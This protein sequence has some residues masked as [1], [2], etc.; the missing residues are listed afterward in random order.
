MRIHWDSSISPTVPML[1]AK[2]TSPCEPTTSST[3]LGL[4]TTMRP[5][6][7]SKALCLLLGAAIHF[8]LSTKNNKLILDDPAISNIGSRGSI[9]FRARLLEMWS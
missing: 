1:L 5:I 8:L 9:L 3:I 4:Q 2:T 7:I 6:L